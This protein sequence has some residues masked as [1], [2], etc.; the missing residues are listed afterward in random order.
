VKLYENYLPAA[1]AKGKYFAKTANERTLKIED[2]AALIVERRGSR[3]KIAELVEA[4]HLFCREIG[5][6]LC[7]GYAVNLGDLFL[8][9]PHVKGM[10]A[11]IREGVSEEHH[12]LTFHFRIL[13][14]LYEAAEHIKVNVLGLATSGAFID[15]F[16]DVKTGLV[17]QKATIGG[18]FITEGCKI[19]IAG[20]SP[21]IGL[22]FTTPGSPAV[23]VKAAEPFAVNEPHQII[24]VIPELLPGKQW[25]LEVRTQYSSSSTLLKEVRVVAS[26]FT[27]SV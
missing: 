18:Q 13:R 10:F 14:A 17:N 1:K 12:P 2:I 20:S 22:F 21:K 15:T 23:A 11:N 9:Y 4:I 7:D 24:G 8:L 26:D 19:K 16:T 25:T 3:W 27:V 6:Q 5:I